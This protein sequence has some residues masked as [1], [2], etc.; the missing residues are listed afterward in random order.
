M[1][2]GLPVAAGND[3]KSGA[4][5]D[6]KSGAGND[7][8][9]SSPTRSGIYSSRKV[10][11]ATGHSARDIYEMFDRKGWELQEKGFALGVRVEHPQSLIN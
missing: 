6:G 7:G 1:S 2:S 5:N 8:A 11:L 9:S 4:G 10:I 3:G